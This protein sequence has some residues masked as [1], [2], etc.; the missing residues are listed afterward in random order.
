MTLSIFLSRKDDRLISQKSYGVADDGLSSLDMKTCYSLPS[1]RDLL[2][3]SQFGAMSR[4][5]GICAGIILSGQ[6]DLQGLK[7]C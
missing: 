2:F 3:E 1:V 4:A 6:A 5:C 7:L